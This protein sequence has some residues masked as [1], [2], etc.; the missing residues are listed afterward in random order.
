[1]L[2]EIHK[3][4]R[5]IIFKYFKTQFLL[6]KY[7]M[8]YISTSERV[9]CTP[10]AGQNQFIEARTSFYILFSHKMYKKT[11]KITKNFFFLFFFHYRRKKLFLAPKNSFRPANGL[12]STCLLVK[13]HNNCWF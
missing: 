9:L 2:R 8:L 6:H 4:H 10:L 12:R 7:C 13:I 5:A 1:M 3:L 11:K